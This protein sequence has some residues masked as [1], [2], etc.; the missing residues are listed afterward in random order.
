MPIN[1]LEGIQNLILDMDGVLWR[2][3][4][5]APGLAPFFAALRRL[6]IGF[7]LA[8]NNAS[9]TPEQYGE[10]LKRFGVDIA[11]DA[12]LTSAEAT[13]GYLR[14]QYAQGASAYVV[15]DVGLRQALLNHGFQLIADTNAPSLLSSGACADLVV[16]GFAP[17]A[18]YTQM[19]NAVQFI[20]AGAAFVGTNP[21]VTFPHESGELPGAGAFLAFIQAATGREPTVIGKPGRAMFEE[22][23]RRLGATA[24]STVMVGDRLGTDISGA[25][26]AGMRAILLLSGVTRPEELENSAARPDLVLADILALTEMIVQQ[27]EPLAVADGR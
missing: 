19:A 25:Q 4:T 18:D 6:Q 3:E 20:F 9:K 8:T 23:L 15:G 7:V 21:D 22:A 16:V 24:S 27:H 12:I 13:A 17:N 5:P 2:G 26:A 1:S 10:K 11:V 14:R